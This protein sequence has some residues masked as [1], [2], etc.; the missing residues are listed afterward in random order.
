MFKYVAL[1]GIGSVILLSAMVIYSESRVRACSEETR[2][3]QQERDGALKLAA[4]GIAA[5]RISS[6]WPAF[7]VWWDSIVVTHVTGDV[8]E[9]A[10]KF[11]ISDKSK[12][13]AGPSHRWS[14][15]FSTSNPIAK[16]FLIDG[17]CVESP[18]DLKSGSDV[19]VI[20]TSIGSSD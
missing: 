2:Q 14:L 9:A 7:V 18:D 20:Q 3:Y 12:R 19:K 17:Q 8:Y 16:S 6:L 10:G 11:D 5:D 13:L 15:V 4:R 1:F